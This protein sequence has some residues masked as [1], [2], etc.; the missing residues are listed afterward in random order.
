MKGVYKFAPKHYDTSKKAWQE[1]GSVAVGKENTEKYH[2]A[3]VLSFVKTLK[4]MGM[5][6]NDYMLNVVTAGVIYNYKQA[7]S[8]PVLDVASDTLIFHSQLL[9]DSGSAWR[10][11]INREIEKCEQVAK[12]V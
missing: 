6:E 1:F 12:K 10:T 3:G 11:R 4:D 2:S 7:T 5:L 8:L 9:L